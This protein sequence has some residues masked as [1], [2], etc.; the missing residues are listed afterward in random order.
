[1]QNDYLQTNIR[2]RADIKA[3]LEQAADANKRSLTAE[4]T[5]RLEESFERTGKAVTVDTRTMDL[6]ADSVA[7]KVVRALD[8]R[9]KK[10]KGLSVEVSA[11]RC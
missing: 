8:E 6:F 1:M 2:I 3:R 5:A 11:T 9:E 7:G 10:K 4:L